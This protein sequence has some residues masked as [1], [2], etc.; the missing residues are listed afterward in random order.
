MSVRK[1]NS[2]FVVDY[3]PEGRAGKRVRL[4]LPNG[5]TKFEDAKAIEREL[6]TSKDKHIPVPRNT[7]VSELFLRYLDWYE[8]HRAATTYRDIKNVFKNHLKRLLGNYLAE[9][10]SE[11]HINVYKRIRRAEH[12]SGNRCIIKELA[13]FS[14]FLTWCA[15]NKYIK[16]RDF[17]IEKLPYTRPIPIVL[18]YKEALK[19]IRAAEPLYR[20][21][22]LVLFNLGL[23]LSSA[24]MLKWTDID[25]SQRTLQI[26]GKGGKPNK[27]PLPKWLYKELTVL[28][29]KSRSQYVFPSRLKQTQPVSDVRKAIER[30]KTRAGITKRIYPHLL[31]HSLA[32]HLLDK[33]I[34]LRTIQDMLGH[35]D[36]K[37][38]EFY[39][40]V[41]TKIKESAFKK[42]GFK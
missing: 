32:T 15:K 7:L 13:Y 29:K 9:E 40:H 37:T 31:R 11:N 10:I 38:T 27:F 20:V 35:K 28:K 22:F 8:M 4:M 30:A 41:S 34:N 42:A 2:K 36:I 19:F 21:F 39:T 12:R 5:V 16:K 1:R 23:R 18:T 6:R 3:Y 33:D 26:T 25:L 14:G 17:M 24:R